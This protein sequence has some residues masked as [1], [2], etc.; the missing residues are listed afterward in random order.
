MTNEQQKEI[1]KE[2]DEIFGGEGVIA[3]TDE[4]SILIGF[5]KKEVKD[6]WLSKLSLVR[7]QT[8]DEVLRET[9]YYFGHI[10]N[11]GNGKPMNISLEEVASDLTT[12]LTKL[13]EPN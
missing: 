4:N 5:T 3:R 9:E 13:K 1:R 6:F 2:F 7:N 8:I 11:D 10:L 12:T